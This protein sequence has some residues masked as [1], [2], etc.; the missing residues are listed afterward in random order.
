VTIA[1]FRKLVQRI[2]EEFENLPNLHLTAFEASR[3]WGL[4]LC[5]CQQVLAELLAA[6][7]VALDGD[8]RYSLVEC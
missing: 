4:D 2:R 1:T 3:F 8:Q 7:S 6:G 5:T